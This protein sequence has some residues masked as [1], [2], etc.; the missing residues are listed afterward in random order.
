MTFCADLLGDVNQDGNVDLIDVQPFIDRLSTGTYQFEADT[1]GD[2]AVNL[3]DVDLFIEILIGIPDDSSL[4][5]VPSQIAFS[6]DFVVD[7][8]LVTVSKSWQCENPDYEYFLDLE[9]E[10]VN[11]GFQDH[12][13]QFVSLLDTTTFDSDALI[14]LVI[15]NWNTDKVPRHVNESY[16]VCIQ[17]LRHDIQ[18]DVFANIGE[19][20]CRSFGPF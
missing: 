4:L 20:K 19:L 6:G 15:V 10:G 11:G 7:A 14:A 17:I 13:S 2:G 9:I 8:V 18:N 12:G 1:N 5:G 3:L 16:T